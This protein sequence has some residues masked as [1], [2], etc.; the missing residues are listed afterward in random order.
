MKLISHWRSTFLPLAF[1]TCLTGLHSATAA[2]VAGPVNAA[3]GINDLTFTANSQ[4]YDVNVTWVTGQSYNTIFGATPPL[5]LDNFALSGA[6]GGALLT[7]LT[8]LG[9]SHLAGASDYSRLYLP[10]S[11]LYNP[12]YTNGSKSA[13]IY[14]ETGN[15]PGGLAWFSGGYNNDTGR[16]LGVLG[17]TTTEFYAVYTNAAPVPVPAAAWLM[18]SGLSGL[19][20]FVRRKR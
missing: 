3:T 7:A 19:G 17:G 4:N 20:A 13:G 8:D 6:A 15:G 2:T 5:F 9:V 11:V 18:L 12:A 1:V 16:V 14:L 10:A